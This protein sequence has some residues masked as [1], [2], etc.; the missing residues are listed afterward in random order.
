MVDR[1]NKSSNALALAIGGLALAVACTGTAVAATGTVV[2]IADGSNAAR[3]AHVDATGHLQVN[4]GGSTVYTYAYQPSTAFHSIIGQSNTTCNA[5]YTPPAGKSAVVTDIN[6]TLW[7]PAAG[8]APSLL[9]L[10]V[11][12]TSTPCNNT[13][14]LFYSSSQANAYQSE[15]TGLGIPDGYS[16]FADQYFGAGTGSWL[17]AVDGYTAPAS[18][19]PPSSAAAATTHAGAAAGK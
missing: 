1:L 18:Y 5:V 2:N 16:L 12:P 3:V 17:I 9:R 14:R 4:A 8:G 13:A 15:H 6:V 7:S 11:L 10:Y 19:V